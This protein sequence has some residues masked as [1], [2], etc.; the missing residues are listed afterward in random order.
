MISQ[1]AFPEGPE[2]AVTKVNVASELGY[3][4]GMSGY[5]TNEKDGVFRDGVETQLANISGN[6]KRGFNMTHSIIV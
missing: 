6:I 3:T 4:K 1:I 5:V 2:S